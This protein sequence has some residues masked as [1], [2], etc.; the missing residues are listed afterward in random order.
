MERKIVKIHE[1]KC[2]GC[3]ICVKA[4]HEGAIQIINGKAKLI[5]DEYCDGLGDCLPGCP[6]GAI[7][8]IEREAVDYSEEA[9]QKLKKEKAEKK[10][11]VQSIPCGCPGTVAKAIVRKASAATNVKIKENIAA[12]SAVNVS[13]LRQWPVQL[14]LIN[15]RAPYL[16]EA[17]LLVAADCTAYAY[18]DFHKD[19]IKDHITVI[20]CPKLDDVKYYEEKLA[21]ILKMNDIKSITVVRMEVPC[22]GGIVNAVKTAMLNSQTIVPY[23]EVII[24]TE[25]NI[26][27]R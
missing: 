11:E 19:F 23:R 1:E 18:A 16:K 17:D 24:G 25:G 6:E 4:C 8:I 9:V 20:G 27:S 2:N 12:E 26:I 15:T 10:N 21:E 5:S 3:G 22:C 14:K 13:E 7:E